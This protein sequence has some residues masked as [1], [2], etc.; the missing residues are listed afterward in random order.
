M[1]SA[2][3]TE[4]HLGP[5]RR[6]VRERPDVRLS[7]EALRRR[8]T[9]RLAVLSFYKQRSRRLIFTMHIL[10]SLASPATGMRNTDDNESPGPALVPDAGSNAASGASTA[11]NFLIPIV[12]LAVAGYMLFAPDAKIPTA[13]TPDFDPAAIDPSPRRQHAAVTPSP[14]SAPTN[15]HV[16]NAMRCSSRAIRMRP[17]DNNTNTSCCSTAA[18]P[19]ATLPRREEPRSPRL[20][21]W[22]LR[23]FA[24]SQELCVKCHGTTYPDWQKGMHGRTTG[25]LDP[26]NPEH[27]RLLCVDATIRMHPLIQPSRPPGPNT[28]RLEKHP[29]AKH[30]Y[31]SP[32]QRWLNE[33]DDHGDSDEGTDRGH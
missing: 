7:T 19:S 1:G 17:S 21:W 30:H 32:L 26:Q 8:M 31:D 3:I 15:T 20:A 29:D 11:A 16:R 12:F 4:P 9:T 23:T 25:S 22:R 2:V 6:R 27:R 14:R 33:S 5:H 18:M 24:R 28:L 10:R 13:A